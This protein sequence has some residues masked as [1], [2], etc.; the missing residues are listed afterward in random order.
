[1]FFPSEDECARITVT[2]SDTTVNQYSEQLS[3]Y[4][5]DTNV[6]LHARRSLNDD[7]GAVV[8]IRS[9]SGDTDIATIMIGLLCKYRERVILD[10]RQ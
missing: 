6:I 10:S 7:S 1:M 5:D 2:A 3:S 8:T 4:E 9:P